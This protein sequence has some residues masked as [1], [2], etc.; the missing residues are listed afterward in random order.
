MNKI[1]I[2]GA[3][4]IGVMIAT[5]LS[6]PD[7]GRS[8]YELTI[9]DQNKA[10][11]AR[12]ANPLGPYAVTVDV[13]NSEALGLLLAQHDIVV[14]ALPYFLTEQVA[15]AAAANHCHYLDLTEDVASTQKVRELAEQAETAFIPQ[16]GLAPG[17]ISIIANHMAARFESVRDLSMRV[18][19]LPKF[20]SN[21]LKY[22]L[23]WSTDGVVNEYLH[24]CEAI[25]NGRK[26][27]VDALEGYSK[28]SLDGIEY[29]CFNTSGGLGSL[30]ETLAGKVQNLNYKTIRY[31]GHNAVMRSLIH[32][33]RLGER[34]ELLKEILEYALPTTLQD[35]VLVYVTANGWQDGRLVQETYTR[36][37]YSREIGGELYSAIQITTASGI[38]AVVDMLYEGKLPTQGLVRQEQISFADFIANRFGRNYHFDDAAVAEPMYAAMPS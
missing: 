10:T 19:A 29:E 32:D 26:T 1:V 8:R 15:T 22:N 37:I 11:F 25:V 12:L 24:P 23:T 9:A 27:M 36:K 38:C 33:L 3:G 20:P 7:A 34:P 14:N 17:F 21:A 6:Q 31:P 13:N 35:V 28:F 18:G 5:L 4:K 30:C 2:L 16:C